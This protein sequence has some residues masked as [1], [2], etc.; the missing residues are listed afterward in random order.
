M[1]LLEDRSATVH[2]RNDHLLCGVIEL[3][4]AILMVGIRLGLLSEEDALLNFRRG[5]ETGQAITLNSDF[6][7]GLELF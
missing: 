4:F 6:L 7:N 2:I 3:L 1:V 5:L